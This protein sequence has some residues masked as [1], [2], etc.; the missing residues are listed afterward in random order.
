[1]SQLRS[2]IH[3][4]DGDGKALPPTP[5]E[6]NQESIGE[7]ATTTSPTGAENDR[8]Y[9]TRVDSQSRVKRRDINERVSETVASLDT[10]DDI[11]SQLE[12]ALG[13]IRETEERLD[14]TVAALASL[15]STDS[16]RQG[17]D[18]IARARDELR[19]DIRIWSRNFHHTSKKTVLKSLKDNLFAQVDEAPFRVVTPYWRQYLSETNERGPSLLV[20]AYVWNELLQE[21][22]DQLVWIGGPCHGL[23][24]KCSS[25]N[26]FQDLRKIA[27]SM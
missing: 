17:D 6:E 11:E 26:A 5:P 23:G 18:R 21:V 22:F 25:Y 20:Q 10:K 1:M 14:D 7:M 4:S 3:E 9:T 2:Q 19:H 27:Y 15:H 12:W 16:F 8:P 24:E 13:K